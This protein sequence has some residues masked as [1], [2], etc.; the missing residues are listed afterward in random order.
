MSLNW[1]VGAASK[2][3]CSHRHLSKELMKYNILASQLQNA[4]ESKCKEYCCAVILKL[5]YQK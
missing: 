2:I 5:K 1:R 4:T 3:D